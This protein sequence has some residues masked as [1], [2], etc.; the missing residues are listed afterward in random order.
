MALDLNN[1]YEQAK[2]QLKA[3]KTFNEV[4]KSINESVKKGPSSSEPD[5]KN[6]TFKLDQAEIEKK[7]KKQVQGQFEQLIGLISSSRG[8]G[9]ATAVF[10]I[11]KFVVA[12]KKLRAKL[13]EIIRTE[14]LKALTCEIDATYEPGTYYIKVSSID[15]FK[16][17]ETDPT[18][19]V[20][21]M[22]YEPQLFVPSASK[23]SNNRL[24]Y[25]LIQNID[26][27]YS[28]TYSQDYLG[29]STNPL[30]DITFVEV[31]PINGNADGWFQVDLK[32][33]KPGEP[34]KV[35]QFLIDYFET[36]SIIQFKTL[37]AAL[38]EAVLGVVSIKLRFGTTTID[39][40]NK[41]GLLV[42]RILGMCFDEAQE[43]TVAGQAKT[44]ELDDTTDSFFEMT[45]LDTSIIEQRTSEIQRGVVSFESCD[46]IQ[47]PV[48]TENVIDIINE[49]VIEE[50]GSGFDKALENITL[51]FMND[52]KWSIQ[53][54]FPDQLKI[55]L[56]FNFVK[57]IPIA[58]VSTVISPK[59]LFPFLTMIAALDKEYD[60]SL[61]GLSNFLR[62]NRQLMK[63]LIS[64]IGAEFIETLFDEIKKDIRT[65]VKS[66]IIDISKDENGTAYLMIE[67]L[68]NLAL[69]ITSIVRDF[70]QC[71]SVIDSILQLFN[72]IPALGNQKIPL[73][74][75]KL[76]TFLPGYSPNRAFINTIS[77][78]Q[79]LGL[80]T[81]PLPDGS[82]NLG[83]QSMYAQIKSQDLEQKVN[84][85]TP[86]SISLPPPFGLVQ[87]MGKSI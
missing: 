62:Q 12:I 43:I 63:N 87:T 52:P 22:L 15:L 7:I 44:P 9:N 76:A 11:K 83:L 56:D 3:L 37:I 73:P 50:D 25:D 84:G 17:L 86:G 40:S 85:L 4:K 24:F 39:D 60:F 55:S 23:R 59:T 65:L 71:K 13:P 34:N 72:L 80:P 66:I 67:R 53:F 19:N 14:I 2:D 48:D 64:K 35:A 16:L 70:R 8:S 51:Y 10:L 20:G 26:V 42:Q 6:S 46:N 82:P 21:K 47:F 18:T 38:I 68:V 77:T 29:K 28:T 36:I 58:V 75:L 45:N 31:N 54:P 33:M 5:K 61:K 74:L 57:K 69:A 41:F 81:G 27:P 1:G 32:E 30:F 49:S 78:L 79:Q